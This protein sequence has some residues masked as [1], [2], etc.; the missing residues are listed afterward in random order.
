M[1]KL[2]VCGHISY[3]EYFVTPLLLNTHKFHQHVSFGS[4]VKA[5]WTTSANDFWDISCIV[6]CWRMW[7]SLPATMWQITSYGKFRQRLK[8]H[9]FRASKSQCI[10]TLIITLHKYSYLLTYYFQFSFSLSSYPKLLQVGLGTQNENLCQIIWAIRR[11]YGWGWTARRWRHYIFWV[12]HSS[13]CAYV[14]ACP[15]GGILRPACTWLLVIYW[16]SDV[17]VAEWLACWTRAQKGHTHRASVY[18]AAKLVA[19]LLRLRG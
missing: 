7:N 15:G 12:V 8:T 3:V 10:V 14:Q 16:C 2:V 18:Q 6:I 4:V 9:L 17:L 13:V 5:L 1:E 19:A 11:S